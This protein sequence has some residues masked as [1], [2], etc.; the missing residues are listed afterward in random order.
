MDLYKGSIPI[1][2][3]EKSAHRDTLF[4]RE[5]TFG[6][7]PRDFSEFPTN[8]FAAL[9]SEMELIPESDYDARY[10]LEEELQSSLEH[11]YMPNGPDG[12]PA[13]VNLD[14]NG[15]G[16]CWAY[17]TGH[18]LMIARLRD[19]LPLVRLNPHSIAVGLSRFNG[20]W[21]GASAKYAREVGCA[22]EGTGPGQFPLHS[23]RAADLTAAVRAEMARYRVAEDW[24]DVARDV[25]DQQLNER[26][27]ATCNFNNIPT[28]TDYNWWG[29]SVLRLRKVRIERG[30]WGALIL[31]S[32]KGWGRFGLAVLRGSQAVADGAVG[33]RA[34]TVSA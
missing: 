24:F 34:A 5:A 4:P 17:S 13:F 1:L 11:F 10:D 33:V 25:W 15:D 3:P 21:C 29:H 27:L 12:P 7:V 20:G 9:P 6:M 19:R 26:Q 28:P 18:A 22:P 31:N 2:E 32:W 16:H 30:S 14:Q 23:N 8:T